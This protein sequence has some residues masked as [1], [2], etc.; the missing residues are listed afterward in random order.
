MSKEFIYGLHCE[1][2]ADNILYIGRTNKPDRRLAEHIRESKKGHTK[3]CKVLRALINDGETITY[4]I[5]ETVDLTTPSSAEDLWI[6]NMEGAGQP[7]CNSKSGDTDRLI[8]LDKDFESTPW[9][10]DLLMNAKW[11]KKREW[12]KTGFI[13][14]IKGTLFIR[15]GFS[16]LKMRHT[17]FGIVEIEGMNWESKCNKAA[18]M[19]TPGTEE[20]KFI[21]QQ[22]EQSKA[23]RPSM[24]D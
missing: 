18:K 21:R 13:T 3:K 15:Q 8:I 4:T 17:N 5:L 9:T 6:T 19:L 7:L 22:Y 20:S 12:S 23:I 2:D 14:W 24:Y 1:S 16:K 10:P 11:E